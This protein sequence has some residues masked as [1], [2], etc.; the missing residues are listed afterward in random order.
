MKIAQITFYLTLTIVLVSEHALI[1]GQ[2]SAAIV[3]LLNQDMILLI[4]VILVIIVSVVFDI[5]E[6]CD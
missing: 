2:K 4:L 3:L 5:V 1:A 6:L